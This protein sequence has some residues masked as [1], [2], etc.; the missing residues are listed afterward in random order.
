MGER[1]RKR[2]CGAARC[3]AARCSASGQ[4]GTRRAVMVKSGP[5]ASVRA[6][7]ATHELGNHAIGSGNSPL[8]GQVISSLPIGNGAPNGTVQTSSPGGRR[9]GEALVPGA[10]QKQLCSS[11]GFRIATQPPEIPLIGG[12]T[13]EIPVT[14]SRKFPV[15]KKESLFISGFWT[16][17]QVFL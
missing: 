16:V 5:A 8:A 2:R 9:L 10:R 3:A 12:T 13:L 1:A 15:R 4:T 11:S 6:A 7:I 17:W 14:L